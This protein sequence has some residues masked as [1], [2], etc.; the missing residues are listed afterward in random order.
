MLAR[1]AMPPALALVAFNYDAAAGQ[2]LIVL[3]PLNFSAMEVTAA[4]CRRV[5][6]GERER[7]RV[8]KED[9]VQFSFNRFLFVSHMVT[10]HAWI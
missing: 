2:E 1:H 9:S 8:G 6:A 10:T 7:E 5:C 4:I 3:V